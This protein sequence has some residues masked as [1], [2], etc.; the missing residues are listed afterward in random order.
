MN[1]F[2]RFYG[3]RF[4]TELKL[5]LA[6]ENPLPAVQRIVEF[7]LLTFFVPNLKLDQRLANLLEECQR[8]LA[9]HKL[10]YLDE[11]C[12]QWLVYL[13]ALFSSI[14]GKKVLDFC[15][16]FEVPERYRQY[17]FEEKVAVAKIVRVLNGRSHYTNSE[18]YWLLR[19]LSHEGLLYLMALTKK[20]AGKKAVS[21]YVTHLRHAKTLLQGD[22]LIAMGYPPGPVFKKILTGLLDARL[23]G[24]VQSRKEEM[25]FVKKEFPQGKQ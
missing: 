13:L 9:W 1:A 22:D 5:I 19:E 21:L 17:I 18:I 25:A 14:P 12:R 2:G 11:K 4:F 6:E 10:L 15:K 16:K 24:S 8:A 23:N 3:Q 7:K 20:K